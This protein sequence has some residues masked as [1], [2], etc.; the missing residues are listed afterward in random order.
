MDQATQAQDKVFPARIS[1]VTVALSE[2]CM[3]NASR[4]EKSP[5]AEAIDFRRSVEVR[6]RPIVRA[7]PAR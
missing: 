5:H 1:E 3:T 2:V 4:P 7:L 6:T